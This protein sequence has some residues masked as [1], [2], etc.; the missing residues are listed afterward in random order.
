MGGLA[1]LLGFDAADRLGGGPADGA[2]VLAEVDGDDLG[3]DVD[4]DDLPGV[5]P[6]QGDPLPGDHDHA[7]VAGHPRLARH[8]ARDTTCSRLR[9]EIANLTATAS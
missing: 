9:R 4:G 2:G 7:G 6:A 5:D 8:K 1:G 3:G